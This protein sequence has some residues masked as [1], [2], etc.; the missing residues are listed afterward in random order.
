MPGVGGPDPTAATCELTSAGCEP[1]QCCPNGHGTGGPRGGCRAGVQGGQ[2]R[3]GVEGPQGEGRP[4][5]AHR[6]LAFM[7]PN[8]LVAPASR[9][10]S[11]SSRVQGGLQAKQ[12]LVSP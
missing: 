7:A 12:L 5:G 8:G 3:H 6:G 4:G 2:G 10:D 9:E 11:R 1:A